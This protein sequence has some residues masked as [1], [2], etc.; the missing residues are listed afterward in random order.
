LLFDLLSDDEDVEEASGAMRRFDIP[1][2]A[3]RLSD[4]SAWV[5]SATPTRALPL[6]Y[7]GASTGAAAALM[8]A[9]QRRDDLRAVVSRGGRP[10]LVP[11]HLLN[12]VAAPTLLI[13]GGDDPEVLAMNRAAAAHL[14]CLHRTTVIQGA[15]H[16]FEEP[17]TL[18]EVAAHA[19]DWF[20]QYLS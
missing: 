15:S 4:V 20:V 6:G 14:R 16:L 2:L 5:R 13:V 10:D 12:E 9:A 1:L 19:R 3:Q 11:A 17:G 18:E 8:A 7:F